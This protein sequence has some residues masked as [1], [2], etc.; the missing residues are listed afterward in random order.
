LGGASTHFDV[1]LKFDFKQKFKT[2]C[3]KPRYLFFLNAAKITAVPGLR[4]QTPFG[5]RLRVVVPDYYHDS[6]A[7]LINNIVEKK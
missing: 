6:K 5:L 4:S 7:N 3:L 2:K 1:I